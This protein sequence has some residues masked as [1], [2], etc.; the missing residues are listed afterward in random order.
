[1]HLVAQDLV[2]GILAGGIF[3][4]VALGFSLVWGIMNI[5]NLAHG[6]FIMLGAYTTYQLVTT[7]GLD[8]FVTL[9]FSFVALFVLGYLIQRLLINWVARA[10]ILTTFLL[11]FGLSLLIVNIALLIWSPD[12]R[13]VHPAY[14][15]TNFT[16]G[17]VTVPWGKVYTLIA[18]LIIT[19]LMHVWLTRS[20]TGRA[21]RAT[22]MD[23]GAAQLSGVR[24]SQI[25]A[26][27]FGLG[28][29]LAGVAGTL[30][31]LSYS[32]TPNMGDPFLIKGFVVCVL[33]GLG[34]V[35]G[36]LLGGLTYGIVEAFATQID[37]TIGTQHIS[38]SGLQD[39][40]ALVV[41]LIVLIVRPRGIMGK[42]VA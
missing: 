6:S 35:Q 16:I 29:G 28:A 4:V 10:P 3:A 25:Y 23:I 26:I 41:L 32:I 42:A 1:M 19:G 21:I 17:D 38:G 39:A 13:G 31:S 36:A 5:I 40:I 15:G 20:R 12:T 7:F 30:L 27:V 11:T 34:S 37:L 18:A 2:N 22:S 14:A 24:V 9:P 33:G 8:P